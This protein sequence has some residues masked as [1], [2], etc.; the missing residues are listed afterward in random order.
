M[1]KRNIKDRLLLI[2]TAVVI[3]GVF[4]LLAYWRIDKW[5]LIGYHYYTKDSNIKDCGNSFNFSGKS[6]YTT[7]SINNNRVTIEIGSMSCGNTIEITDLKVDKKM[8]VYIK[9]KEK[10]GYITLQCGYC[11]PTA[12]IYFFKKD[13]SITLVKEDETKLDE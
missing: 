3:V 5:G 6:D 10:D 9:A 2:L 4:I 7:Y 11:T 13:K 8:N 12:T 1:K